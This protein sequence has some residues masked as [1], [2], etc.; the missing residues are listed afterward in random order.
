MTANGYGLAM[1]GNLKNVSPNLAQSSIE[2]QMLN[3][4]RQ[5]HYCQTDV[6]GWHY[7]FYFYISSA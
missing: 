3:Y 5:P 1:V 4:F 6:S 7:L 2:L